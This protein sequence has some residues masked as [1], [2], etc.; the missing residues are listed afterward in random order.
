MAGR[1]LVLGVFLLSTTINYLDRQTLANVAP[2]VLQEFSLSTQQYGWIVAAFSLTYAFAAPPAGLMIDRLGLTRG[3]S[4]A[5]GLWSLAG[6]ATGLGTGMASLV[7]CR[8]ILGMAEAGG[9]PATGKAIRMY[10]PPAERALGTSL[11]QAALSLGLI[12]A[13]PV[14]TWI[15]VNWGWRYAFLVT[16]A[17]GLAWLPLWRAVAR[18]ETEGSTTLPMDWAF[19]REPLV[20]WFGVAS[21]VSLILQSFWANF[22]FLYL[23][24]PA[25]ANQEEA[26]WLATIP[27]VAATM[28]GLAGGAAS[29][30]LIRKG[31]PPFAAR[32][33]VCGAAGVLALIS[34]LIPGA[35]TAFWTTIGISAGL[36]AVS[37]F[38]VNMYAIPLDVYPV[39]RAAFAI[40]LLTFCYGIM[41][42]VIS[43]LFGA[44]IDAFGY[45]PISAFAAVSPLAAWWILRVRGPRA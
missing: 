21:A 9:I 13:P 29:F 14:A 23:T 27:P 4:A 33:R 30:R 12:L 34:A 35:P 39:E 26:A 31:V 37:A 28:G 24:G 19:A 2:Q 16:G 22:T 40:S 8:A 25:G 17:L 43:P 5:I 41:Q 44:V 7:L 6:I 36:F 38:S 18:P 10:L 15:A 20:W 1:W 11:N 45:D 32:M 3:I 42:A